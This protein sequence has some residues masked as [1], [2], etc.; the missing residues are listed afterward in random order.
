MLREDL[1]EHPLQGRP[2]RRRYRN[3]IA[4]AGSYFASLGG[5]LPY[6]ARLRE[7]EAL[8][9]RHERELAERYATTDR[10]DVAAAS[11]RAGASTR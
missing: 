11:R 1:V 3:F 9:V 2:L 10:G 4:D 5:P 6:M 7:L 8:I